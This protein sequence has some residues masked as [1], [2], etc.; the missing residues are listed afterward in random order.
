MEMVD[1]ATLIA[2]GLA[3]SSGA[4]AAHIAERAWEIVREVMKEEE[5]KAEEAP[6]E[7]KKAKA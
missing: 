4:D 3:T 5:L 1:R 7:K 6:P 2:A